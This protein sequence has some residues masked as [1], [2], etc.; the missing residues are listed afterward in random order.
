M[1]TDYQQLETV[2]VQLTPDE[3]RT[4]LRFAEFLLQQRQLPIDARTARRTV[5]AWLV[6]DVG[7]LLMGGE[8]VYVPGD[9]PIWRVPVLVSR[10]QRGCASYINVDAYTGD[11]L[12]TEHTSEKVLRDV[13]AFL[14]SSSSN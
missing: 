7:N 5:S 2:L 1:A 11:L 14:A 12:I 9:R 13:R 6:R 3:S 10:G 4:V 8:P